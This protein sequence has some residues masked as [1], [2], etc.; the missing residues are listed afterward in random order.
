M[1]D[2][3]GLTALITGAAGGLG[4]GTA[5]A[6]AAEGMNLVLADIDLAG[7]E[8]TAR[9]AQAE[10]VEAI[11][12]ACDVARPD[13]F[14]A[15]KAQTL[16]RFGPPDIVM[17]NVGVLTGGRPEDL[18]PEEWERVLNTNLM[19]VVRSNAAFLRDM[20]ER[21][22]GHIVNV[23]STAGLYPYA[24][25]RGPYAASKA[26]IINLT[27]GL[28]L[29]LKPRGVGVTLMCP[30]PMPTNIGKSIRTFGPPL[31]VRGPGADFAPMPPQEAGALIVEAVKAD[32]FFVTTHPE[33]VMKR[34][35]SRLADWDQ[36]IADTAQEIDQALNYAD[37]PT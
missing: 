1:K 5:M 33:P 14:E 18:P 19:S 17:N 12:A 23:A 32:R 6:F 30:G 10:G 3:K 28:A 27:E 21:G 37:R 34:L 16:K 11:A 2:L 7:A 26:A 24:F 4:R 8:E 25:D 35:R 15:L 31:G 22:S 29:Y 36:F 13:A 20:V 9:L